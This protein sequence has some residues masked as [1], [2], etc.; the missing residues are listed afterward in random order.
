MHRRSWRT[1]PGGSLKEVLRYD[2]KIPGAESGKT[3]RAV[4][5]WRGLGVQE[6]MACSGNHRGC[7]AEWSVAGQMRPGDHETRGIR[8]K[9][10]GARPRTWFHLE[11]REPLRSSKQGSEG[12]DLCL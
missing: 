5:T 3:F 4:A 11:A 7:R 1:V 9:E 8:Q 10:P 6:C 12:Q 2:P